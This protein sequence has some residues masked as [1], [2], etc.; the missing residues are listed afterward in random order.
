MQRQVAIPSSIYKNQAFA[1]FFPTL[2]I[3]EKVPHIISGQKLILS[4]AFALTKDPI[5]T[6]AIRY[7]FQQIESRL[8]LIRNISI[9]VPLAQRLSGQWSIR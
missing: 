9:K 7:Q 3:R 2:R 4:Y 5:V 1:S 6:C 8:V